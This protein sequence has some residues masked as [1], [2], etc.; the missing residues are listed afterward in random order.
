MTMKSVRSIMRS[1]IFPKVFKMMLQDR[2]SA[3]LHIIFFS[4][5]DTK[6]NQDKTCDSLQGA[7]PHLSCPDKTDT[8]YMSS[9]RYLCLLH[10]AR[11]MLILYDHREDPLFIVVFKVGPYHTPRDG[12]LFLMLYDADACFL[13]LS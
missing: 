8:S 10:S 11:K 9:E 7:N 5:N 12:Q 3:K 13:C 6:N 2:Y 1:K 4:Q